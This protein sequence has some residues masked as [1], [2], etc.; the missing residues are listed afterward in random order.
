VRDRLAQALDWLDARTAR[1]RAFLLAAAVVAVAGAWK[2]A[3]WD[4]LSELRARAAVELPLLDAQLP[5]LRAQ[6]DRL[7]QALS[8]DPNAGARERKQALLAERAGLDGRLAELTDG[9]IP[10]DEMAGVLR[11]LVR[12]EPGL[13][14][15]RLEALAAEPVLVGDM[16]AAAAPVP[17]EARPALFKHGMVIELRG[18]YLATLRYLESLEA[19][20][21]RFFWDGLDYE[22]VDYPR[23]RV[24][25]ELHSLSLLEGFLGV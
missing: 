6:L 9:L 8:A 23:A 15:V 2:L 18:D 21:W 17:S 14:L 11:E 5:A 10:P 16:P 13:A 25:I 1:E 24:R 22:V 19:L 3:L 4:P 12:A 7:E 20:P